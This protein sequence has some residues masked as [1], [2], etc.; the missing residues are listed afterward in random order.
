MIKL[1]NTEVIGW[2]HA[3]RGMRNPKNSWDRGDTNMY[4]RGYVRYD[5]VMNDGKKMDIY[6]K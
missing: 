5:D 6:L 2:E 1:E 3:I 4:N